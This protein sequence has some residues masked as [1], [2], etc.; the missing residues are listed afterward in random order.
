MRGCV[1]MNKLVSSLLVASASLVAANSAAAFIGGG[2]IGGGDTCPYVGI[3]YKQRWM[4][5]NRHFAATNSG[6][7]GSYY[8]GSIYVGTRCDC[9]GLEA[10]LEGAGSNRRT[11]TF[12]DGSTVSARTNLW[13]GYL[14]ALAYAPIADCFEVLGGF[15]VGVLAPKVNF[16]GAT[17]GAGSRANTTTGA[18]RAAA[19]ARVRLG[20]NYMVSECVGLRGVL[21]WE[22]TENLAVRGAVVTRAHPFGNSFTAQVGIFAKF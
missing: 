21:G 8:G 19:V 3:D 10:G 5:D 4:G 14:D 1:K 18:S 15:G 9:Y 12:S 13:G 17:G 16:S 11:I 20:A 22:S 2:L 7:K 6:R